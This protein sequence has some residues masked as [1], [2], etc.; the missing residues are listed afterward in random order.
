MSFAPPGGGIAGQC[1]WERQVS[2]L[3]FIKDAETARILTRVKAG[4][5]QLSFS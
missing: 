3:T 2:S 1:A 5:S 4:G